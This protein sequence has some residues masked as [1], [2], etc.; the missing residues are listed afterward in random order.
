[1]S[2]GQEERLKLH[3]YPDYILLRLYTSLELLK[4]LFGVL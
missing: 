3:S 1:M 2:E 4:Y